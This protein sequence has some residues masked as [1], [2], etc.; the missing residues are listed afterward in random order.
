MF[1]RQTKYQQQASR[2]REQLSP[3]RQ[4]QHQVAHQ[5]QAKVND[6]LSQITFFNQHG[7]DHL[8]A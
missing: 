6:P 5:R 3:C 8:V 1:F 2:H 4:A 7:R